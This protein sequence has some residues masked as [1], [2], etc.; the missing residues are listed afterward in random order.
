MTSQYQPGPFS[1]IRYSREWGIR[2]FVQAGAR[3]SALGAFDAEH[4]ELILDIAEDEIGSGHFLSRQ[5]GA[6]SELACPILQFWAV[7]MRLFLAGCG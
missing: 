6:P 7:Q 1:R 5:A 2:W 3:P 4:V